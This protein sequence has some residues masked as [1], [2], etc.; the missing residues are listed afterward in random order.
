MQIA[1]I[2]AAAGLALASLSAATAADARDHDRDHRQ[3][4]RH[5]DRRAY[6]HDN[7][8]HY[9]WRNNRGYG[10]CRVEW[11]HHRRMRICR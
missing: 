11:R 9:G 2:F 4:D 1:H 10:H 7:G 3:V 5:D 8:H 6:R